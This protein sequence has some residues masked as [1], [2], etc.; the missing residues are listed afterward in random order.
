MRA[1]VLVSWHVRTELLVSKLESAIAVGRTQ[2]AD[3]RIVKRGGTHATSNAKRARKLLE[4]E[5]LKY[6][7][8]QDYMA[9]I[10][11]IEDASKRKWFFVRAL[12]SSTDIISDLEKRMTRGS[13]SRVR[14]ENGGQRAYRRAKSIV[15]EDDNIS[16]AD[17]LRATH[18]GPRRDKKDTRKPT[19]KG[20]T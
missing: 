19:G 15:R 17:Y 4:G 16:I 20:H 12:L 10:E 14:I 9:D 18:G 1:G 2:C 13:S 3:G 11:Q 8:L 7:T 6:D 5:T